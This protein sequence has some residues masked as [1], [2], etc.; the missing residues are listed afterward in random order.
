[1]DKRVAKYIE[2]R[3]DRLVSMTSEYI[4]IRSLSGEEGEI[5][6]YLVGHLEE[7][8]FSAFIDSTGNVVAGTER[9]DPSNRQGKTLVFNIHM[10][11]VPA[12]SLSSWQHDPFG[13]K[14]VDGRIYGRGAC[15]TKGAWEPMILA[16]EAVRQCG[17]PL[18]GQVLFTGSVMEEVTYSIGTK[19]LMESAFGQKLP[20]YVVL[21]EPTGLT[22]ATGHKGRMELEITTSG[23]SCHASTP[24]L[25][26]NALYK[27]AAAIGAVEKLAAR[28][29]NSPPDPHFG[30][31][32]VAL[33]NITCNPGAQ[34]VVP[35]LCTMYI[36]HR[37]VPGE[38]PEDFI[39]LVKNDLRDAGI[40]A[41]VRLGEREEQT[42]TGY[43][44]K[45]IKH[46][47]GFSMDHDHLLVKTAAAA[48][49]SV[50]GRDP[51]VHRWN[52]ATDGGWTNGVLGIPTIGFS[53]GEEHLA[54]V[55][56]EY[57][58]ITDLA[59]AA[60]VYAEIIVELLGRKP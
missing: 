6:R 24:W 51:S 32:T 17:V 11:T 14:V 15:D 10:D 16:M 56:D 39:A 38:N 48:V 26:E 55:A 31:T 28:I 41:E 49:S 19:M 60:K 33:T 18:D 22:I 50:T 35:D 57:V 20:D 9:F 36:D 23:K 13:G 1:M 27:A 29:D 58:T 44:F 3:K 37:F 54:H 40:D 45:G 2:D 46:M 30:K 42:Y 53:P 8:G 7:N 21:G 43:A 59:V 25:G 12:G 34:N 4:R 5:A 52:F 47:P